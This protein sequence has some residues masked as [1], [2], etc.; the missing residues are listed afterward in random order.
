VIDLAAAIGRL[1][2]TNFRVDP[3]LL[4]RLSTNLRQR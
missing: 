3:L 1:R 2:D 4:E